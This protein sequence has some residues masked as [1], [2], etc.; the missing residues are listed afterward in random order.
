MI[1]GVVYKKGDEHFFTF[2]VGKVP[3]APPGTDHVFSIKDEFAANPDEF[4]PKVRKE[5]D[6]RGIG[7]VMNL[8]E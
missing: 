2:Q 8:P 3:K 7:N 4:F 5:A 1:G 6:R